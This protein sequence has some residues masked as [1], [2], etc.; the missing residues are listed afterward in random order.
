MAVFTCNFY[1]STLGTGSTMTV[2]LPEQAALRRR[3]VPV[4][5]LLHGLLDDHSI[6]LRRTSIE[7][8]AESLNVAIVMPSGGRSFYTNMAHGYRYGDFIGDELPALARAFFPLSEKREETFVAG[9]SMGGY[10]ALRLALTYPERYAAVAGLSSAVRAFMDAEMEDV[11]GPHA[12]FA[13]SHHDLATLATAAAAGPG[14]APRIYLACGQQ[15]FL[16]AD[17]IALHNHLRTLP[18]ELRWEEGPGDHSW[19]YWDAEIQ[20]V[21]AWLPLRKLAAKK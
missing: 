20:K 4:L 11:F 14:P 9:L 6:W 18:L 2:I 17:N 1:A 21:L 15:D 3:K 19:A 16:Y 7:R 8:Y 10:G 5:F 12:Q 13:G